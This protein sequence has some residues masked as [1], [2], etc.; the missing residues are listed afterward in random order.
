MPPNRLEKDCEA[1]CNRVILCVGLVVLALGAL[2]LLVVW[3]LLSLLIGGLRGG[4][5]QEGGGSG[6]VVSVG[7]GGQLQ[8]RWTNVEGWMELR[9][10]HSHTRDLIRR[11][12]KI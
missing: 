1:F 6:I 9:G 2:F 5:S 8:T 12:G 3:S 4:G 7:E 10:V 11:M